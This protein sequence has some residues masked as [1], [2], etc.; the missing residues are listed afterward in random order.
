MDRRRLFLVRHAETEYFSDPEKVHDE[1]TPLTAKGQ[2]QAQA[3]AHALAN[4]RFDRVITSGATRA[5]QTARIIAEGSETDFEVWGDLREI[6]SGSPADL[7][8]AAVDA[9]FSG[10]L[11]GIETDDS[12]LFGGETVG[13]LLE[14]VSRALE[15]LRSD[16]GWDAALVVLH[17]VVNRA[18]LSWALTNGEQRVLFGN[19]EQAF[20]CVN[21]IDL[22]ADDVVVRM[23]NYTPYDPLHGENRKT[24]ME[25]LLERFSA[26]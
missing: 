12:T 15:R 17:G 9:T 4:V 16:D 10:F 6:E 11:K 7:S 20:A 13:H 23:M 18:V 24:T 25:G 26:R 2:A 14:R 5:V 22:G 19:L 8:S 21:I 3:V 1:H